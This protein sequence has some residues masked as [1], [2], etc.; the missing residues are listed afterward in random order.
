LTILGTPTMKKPL[1]C[2]TIQELQRHHGAL[3]HE[4]Q[5]PIKKVG[6]FKLTRFRLTKQIEKKLKL[7][8]CKNYKGPYGHFKHVSCK[9]TKI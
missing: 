6:I 3:T 2:E 8:K 7:M 4:L 9:Y 5:K 1:V